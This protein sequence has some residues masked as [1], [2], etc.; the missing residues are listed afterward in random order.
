MVSGRLPLLLYTINNNFFYIL[1][2]PGE[3]KAKA[4]PGKLYIH[5]RNNKNNN[6]NNKPLLCPI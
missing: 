2:I 6:Y 3:A 4:M 1:P 5:T